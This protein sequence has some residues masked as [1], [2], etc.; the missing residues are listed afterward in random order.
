MRSCAAPAG[1]KRTVHQPARGGEH[2]SRCGVKN[3]ELQKLFQAACHFGERV[4]DIAMRQANEIRVLRNGI[5]KS[6]HLL[7]VGKT[8]QAL[9]VL[10]ELV[11]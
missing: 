1:S 10:R 9:D 7:R 8:K 2:G 5:I 3:N 6:T 4:T 11:K